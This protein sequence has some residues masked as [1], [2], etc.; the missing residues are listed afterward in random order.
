MRRMK[1]ALAAAALTIGGLA[2]S[3]AHAFDR[4]SVVSGANL[5]GFQSVY[6]APVKVSLESGE[7]RVSARDAQAK[8]ADF[9]NEIV[10][11]FERSHAIA[12]APGPDV[13]TVAATLTRL[14]ANRPTAAD[15]SEN[16]SLSPHSF[17]A[18]G[19]GFEAAF[20]SGRGELAFVADDYAGFLDETA[21][22][23]PLW[24]D[25]DRAFSSWARRLQDFVE[26][27]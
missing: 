11:A 1:L 13:L 9:R 12:S 8:S 19:A 6:V 24:R 17:Y 22:T 4:A 21:S 18:G 27:N 2:G 7:R 20:S 10:G 23:A 5:S 15:Y 14:A 25:A 16:P 3:A 26:E